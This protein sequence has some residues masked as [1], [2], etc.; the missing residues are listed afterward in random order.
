M[1]I[2]LP[3]TNELL[4]IASQIVHAYYL[5]G[6]FCFIFVRAKRIEYGEWTGPH[7]KQNQLNKSYCWLLAH[8]IFWNQNDGFGLFYCLCMSTEHYWC[9]FVVHQMP[10]RVC[11]LRLLLSIF[12]SFFCFRNLT[13]E[14][15]MCPFICYSQSVSGCCHCGIHDGAVIV[16]KLKKI[17]GNVQC[18]PMDK[19]LMYIIILGT[20][21]NYL[22]QHHV[23]DLLGVASAI[24]LRSFS[25]SLFRY[26][27]LVL[28]N[29]LAY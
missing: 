5:W 15:S 16:K 23:I 8:M 9:N 10:F 1:K 22:K 28:I 7:E 17:F 27:S 29:A 2:W 20:P 3:Q 18:I 6:T 25:L 11:Q 21:G 13:Y 12:G 14:W 19:R 26:I 4:S 24:Y